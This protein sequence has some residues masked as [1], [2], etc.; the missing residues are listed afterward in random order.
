MTKILAF[1]PG[2]NSLGMVCRDTTNENLINQITTGV[3]IIRDNTEPDRR[4]RH[5]SAASQRRS[6]RN[7]RT[8]YRSVKRRKQA[9]LKLLIKNNCCPLDVES[10]NKWRFDDDEKGYDRT[11]PVDNKAFMNWINFKFVID[12]ETIKSVYRLREILATKPLDY[13]KPDS[14][15]MLGRAIYSIAVRR[16][17][18]SSRLAN[19]ND[20]DNDEQPELQ[21]SEEELSA[22]LK[23]YMREH[24]CPTVGAAF[25]RMERVDKIRIRANDDF[26]PIRNQLKKEIEVIFKVQQRDTDSELYKGL[27]SEKK[28]E[29]T[30]FYKNPLKSQKGK[31]EYC[32]LEPG[33]RKCAKSHPANEFNVAWQLLNNIKIKLE[34]GWENIPLDMRQ[35][36][37]DKLF[38]RNK[39]HF[40]FAEIR[41]LLQ[42]EYGIQFEYK[43]SI[44]YSDKKSVPGCPVTFY[45]QKILGSS[46]ETEK[47]QGNKKRLKHA[48]RRKKK[49]NKEDKRSL[50]EYTEAEGHLTEY[51]AD[52]IWHICYE[53]DEKQFVKDFAK[54]TLG[55]PPAKVISMGALWEA[56]QDGYANL[57]LCALK[58]INPFLAKG[59][60]YSDAV[61][62]ANLP[63]IM[64]EAFFLQNEQDIITLI[65]EERGNISDI[66]RICDIANKLISDYKSL[67]MENLAFAEHNCNYTLQE[68]D[69]ADVKKVCA[70]NYG[71]V[72]EVMT[73]EQQSEVITRVADLYQDF[74]FSGKRDYYKRINLAEALKTALAEKYPFLTKNKLKKLYHH[75]DNAY[76]PSVQPNEDGVLQLGSPA[77]G[78]L[79]NPTVLKVLYKIKQN[80]NKLLANGDID[81]DTIIVVENAREALNDFNMRWAIEEYNSKR[82]RENKAIEDALNDLAKEYHLALPKESV[83]MARLALYQN[84]NF[85]P[86]NPN[87]SRRLYDKLCEKYKLWLKQGFFDFYTGR[88]ITISQ[89]F[90]PDNI[91]EVDHILPISKSFDDSISNK[92]LS[93]SRYNSSI[94]GI[95]LPCELP[96]YLVDTAEGKA[97]IHRIHE[98]EDKVK[99]LEEKVFYWKGRSSYATDPDSKN[100]A[101]KQMHLWQ[102]EYNEWNQRL[103]NLTTKEIT[104]SFRNNQLNDTRTISKYAYHYLKSVFGRVV[105]QRGETTAVFRKIFGFQE[106]YEKK[107]RSRH[108][109]H[110]IDALTLSLIPYGPKREMMMELW[111]QIQEAH[112]F[113]DYVQ[114]RQL[115]DRLER[116]KLLCG[117]G[118]Y[119]PDEVVRY[120]EETTL[121]RNDATNHALT[122]NIKRYRVRGK[123]VPLRDENGNIVYEKTAKGIKRVKAKH[124]SQGNSIRGAIHDQSF[125]G[126][127]EKW[128]DDGSH[129]KEELFVIRRKIEFKAGNQG[130]GFSSWEGEG[131][132]PEKDSLK[133]QMVDKKLYEKFRK[134]HPGKSFKEACAEGFYTYIVENDVRRKV[135]VRHVRCIAKKAQ[136]LK[137]HIFQS[138]HSDKEQYYYVSPGE[139][140]GIFEYRSEDGNLHYNL[141]NL[142]TL[143]EKMKIGALTETPCPKRI[144]IKGVEYIHTRTILKE[145]TILIYPSKESADDQY[146]LDAATVS[147]RLFRINSIE[148]DKRLKLTRHNLAN[149][150]TK[151]NS[152]SDSDFK[153]LPDGMRMAIKNLNFLLLG[154]DF[155]IIDGRIVPI[156]YD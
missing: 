40:D 71:K 5:S 96:N 28:H 132:K 29:G 147:K 123:V 93:S 149:S 97:I 61:M 114:E 60:K 143:S 52:D 135:K 16:G 14:W 45:L 76:Y 88:P 134:Q 80:V 137:K 95:K 69:I 70:D 54:D 3:D 155:D 20:T 142:F 125:Y 72:W 42:D 12:G 115:K 153:D 37:Y 17:F 107:D 138:Q 59:Y 22:G 140:Y 103:T 131:G 30:I 151:R 11:F 56:I 129:E 98:I 84:A 90:S 101:I 141:D 119:S 118:H 112:R 92:V 26:K 109:H 82:E 75:S 6:F 57:S 19:V 33:K 23:Q 85:T 133:S 10:L 73:D 145:D 35:T 99:Y 27:T 63:T 34:N 46:W 111:Y 64:G 116:E 8:R 41:E 127:I 65:D 24:N 144:I 146:L 79:R 130:S 4:G 2:T 9:T 110:A 87:E 86:Y 39:K 81:S 128:K 49:F 44:N 66:N 51:S 152:I 7:T 100:S 113:K 104:P 105:I 154:K 62:L 25:S 122:K 74:F 89:L 31:L 18:K 150:W 47:I 121:V 15:L 77:R 32:T 91:V 106:V 126:K 53:S 55:L 48:Q 58:K 117:L 43:E 67:K 68:D 36:L 78:N 83:T 139:A 13:T 50:K 102:M 120:I 148:Q 136:P 1:D 124:V 108:T 94:K 38:L 156:N 21:K